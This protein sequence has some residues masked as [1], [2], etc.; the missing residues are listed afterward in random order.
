MTATPLHTS[1]DDLFNLGA[2]M[3]IPDFA[4]N[5]GLKAWR[6]QMR[7]VKKAKDAVTRD[8]WA[9]EHDI[10]ISAPIPASLRQ[11]EQQEQQS[12]LATTSQSLPSSSQTLRRVSY[13]DTSEPP[14]PPST[15]PAP[16]GSPGAVNRPEVILHYEEVTVKAIT[17]LADRF[18]GHMIRRTPDSLDAEGKALNKL[19]PYLSRHIFLTPSSVEIAYLSDAALAERS[20]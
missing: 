7:L 16:S 13:W 3:G 4:N 20:K 8:D 5:E 2:L 19:H 6:E 10:L 17:Y 9:Q 12:N 11:P 14:S 18:E 15:P 1:P